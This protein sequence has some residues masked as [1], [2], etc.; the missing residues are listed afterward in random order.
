LLGAAILGCAGAFAQSQAQTYFVDG[1][2]GGVYGHYP[3][4]FTDVIVKHLDNHQDW[5]IGLEIEPETWDVVSVYEPDAYLRFRDYLNDGSRAEYTNPSWA[6]PYMY[7]VLGESIIRQMQVGMKTLQ[8][9]FPNLK[10][11]TYAV[12]EPCFTS[13]LP[14]IL[15]SLGFSYIST[16]NPN[17]MFGGYFSQNDA[18]LEWWVGPDGESRLL[19]SPR[20]I[21]ANLDSYSSWSSAD[22]SMTTRYVDASFAAG[23]QN[24]VGMC[25]QDAGWTWGPWLSVKFDNEGPIACAPD[26]ATPMYVLWSEYFE[27]YAPL[28]KAK[29]QTYS[30]EDVHPTLMW[31]AQTVQ[32][33][34]QMVRHSEN[35]I[36]Q[37]EKMASLAKVLCGSD[38]PESE[39]LLGWQGVLRAQHH[40]CWIVPGNKDR[41]KRTW[42]ENSELWTS[43]CDILSQRAL[44]YAA[45]SILSTSE[46]VVTV[47]N[48][49]GSP[50]TEMV[51]IKA[52][53]KFRSIVDAQGNAV[54]CQVG[55]D[56]V[57][58]FI[59]NV[60]AL[61]WASFTLSTEASTFRAATYSKTKGKNVVIGNGLLEVAFSPA[62]G[63][64]IVSIK[65][66]VTKKELINTKS[67]FAFN[68]LQAY[69]PEEGAWHASSDQIGKVSVVACGP[70]KVTAL[71]EGSINGVPFEQ[72]V[73]LKAGSKLIDCNLT[74]KWEKGS[75]LIGSKAV[76]D[77]KAESSSN[78][79]GWK[80]PFYD[81]RYKMNLTFP[82]PAQGTIVKDAPF[83]VC[84]STLEDTFYARLDSIKHN[85]ILNWV[86][87][88]TAKGS[89]ALLCDHTASYTYGKDFPLGLTVQYVGGSPWGGKFDVN[90]PSVINYAIMPHA[91]AWDK[92]GLQATSASWQ[93]K[94]LA[95]LGQ[96]A[97][98]SN[99]LLSLEGTG[100]RLSAAYYEGND[101]CIRLFNADGDNTVKVLAPAFSFDKATLVEL[102]GRVKAELGGSIEVSMPRLGFRT[103]RFTNAR[104]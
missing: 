55:E 98:T 51:S 37:A 91:G 97:S 53:P 99:S 21:S 14:T 81:G 45:G 57:L 44:E 38:Y 8:R 100:Y 35:G 27:K 49:T 54:P 3:E 78:R 11:T 28:Q 31:G 12:E 48:T 19:N 60:P 24:P 22:H 52:D 90:G 33:L 47:F 73:T 15:S 82:L 66:C 84:T 80:K 34:A 56:G 68:G 7:N 36:L 16:K 10:V 83:D 85:V 101:L 20:Y 74:I 5:K 29:E 75:Q 13:S 46:D 30:Q 89:M 61:G 93:E 50:C 103:I 1:Y 9:H 71:V 23:V 96:P 102:D 18:E 104:R 6:Q 40:D 87:L 69:Y 76:E 65:D 59:A 72:R 26:Y 95:V 88:E 86:D 64:S 62:K 43:D 94:P 4:H 67:K 77:K 70:A 39:L 25:Y 92:D 58:E 79:L 42:V 41:N 63:G 17:T 32:H 2:H